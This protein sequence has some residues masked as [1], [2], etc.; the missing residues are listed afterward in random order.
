MEGGCCAGNESAEGEVVKDFAAVAPYVCA[1]VLAQTLIVEAVDGCDLARF[2][3]AADQG[4]AVGVA[5]FEAEEEEE[6]F[7]RVEAA[8][9][10]VAC[11]TVSLLVWVNNG[12]AIPMNR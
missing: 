1:A 6:G 12:T 2:V 9:D 11:T 3:V 5:D 7:K 10:K 8:V 4:Y